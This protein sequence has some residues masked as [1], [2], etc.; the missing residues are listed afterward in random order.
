MSC[1]VLGS[2][3]EQRCSTSI[4]SAKGLRS[5]HLICVA[6]VM[7]IQ[8]QALG[9][10]CRLEPDAARTGGKWQHVKGR[11]SRSLGSNAK[12]AITGG[13]CASSMVGL[14][15]RPGHYPSE[16][17]SALLRASFQQCQPAFE[18]PK[19]S[20]KRLHVRQQGRDW[21]NLTSCQVIHSLS[22]RLGFLEVGTKVEAVRAID[23]VLAALHQA[24][25][26]G[27][28]CVVLSVKRCAGRSVP[29]IA[30][31]NCS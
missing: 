28:R 21:V 18:T 11:T 26:S 5:K 6:L 24:G 3:I 31:S 19:R 10:L 29:S 15:R 27:V 9:E 16:G 25:D 14:V 30:T 22:L 17:H 8:A 7:S 13:G 20:T 12:G 1:V 2:S 4:V 23:P